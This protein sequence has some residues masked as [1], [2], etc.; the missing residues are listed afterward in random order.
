MSLVKQTCTRNRFEVKFSFS[1]LLVIKPD[2]HLIS[3]LKRFARQVGATHI[4]GHSNKDTPNNRP[5][6]LVTLK[7]HIRKFK[8]DNFR[9]EGYTLQENR[10]KLTLFRALYFGCLFNDAITGGLE[11]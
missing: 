7:R 5:F 11:L 2:F 6:G 3:A 1:S 10:N 9:L 4:R 8:K